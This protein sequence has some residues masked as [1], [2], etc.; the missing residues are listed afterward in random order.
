M[1][2]DS[3][4]S[5]GVTKPFLDVKQ[6]QITT[7]RSRRSWWGRR[8]SLEK[9]LL[10]IFL[11]FFIIALVTIILL[12]SQTKG[13]INEKTKE[14]AIC[15]SADCVSTASRVLE[16]MDTTVDPCD[17]FFQY[18]CGTWNRKNIIPDDR[19]HYN[20]FSKL[21]DELQVILKGLLEVPVSEEEAIGIRNAK[22]LYKSCLNMNLIE[23]RGDGPLK[24]L[25]RDIGGW[26]VLDATWDEAKFDWV[27]QAATLRLLNNRVL[28]NQWVSSDDK[29]SSINVIQLDQTQLGMPSRDYFLKE[30]REQVNAYQ[31][32]AQA[33]AEALGANPNTA[34]TEMADMVA[35]ESQ[36][37]NLTVP[38]D[39]RRDTEALYNRMSIRELYTN[40][41]DLID[42]HQYLNQIFHNVSIN[43]TMDD[44]VIVYAPDFLRDL[45]ELVKV[46]SKRTVA[47]YMTWRIVMN[48]VSNMPQKYLDLRRQYNKVLFGTDTDR[49]RWRTCVN[50]AIDNFGMAVGR[51]FVQK[52][53]NEE[54][55]TSALEMIQNIRA[56]FNELL[57]DVPW[58][59]ETTRDVAK[60]KADAIQEK[61]GYPDYIL[62]NTALDEDYEGME[63]DPEKY[64]ENVLKMLNIATQ[65][66]LKNLPRPVD[67]TK[68]STTPVIVNA[69]Y[70]ATKNQIM[71][72][73]AIFQP[74]FYLD[75]YPKS[76]NYGGIA[77]VI[78]HELTHS[79][80][81]RGRQFDKDGN[82]KQWWSDD[83]VEKFKNKAQCI[84]DQYDDYLVVEV[85]KTLNG[86]NTQG[87]NIADN[88]G[89][90]QAFRAYRSWVARRGKE[91]DLLPGV[92]LS[93]NQLFFL[94]FAQIWCGNSRPQSYIQAISSGRHSPG[95]F[96]VIGALSNSYDFAEAYKCPVGSSMNPQKKCSVW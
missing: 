14:Q 41:T 22:Y 47:N 81:D 7:N 53:F 25:L 5:A 74:P 62:N 55:K 94:N 23:E 30:D 21:R 54:A 10:C 52:Y 86:K 31:R 57:S 73:A 44:Q 48:R 27:S 49:A 77:V 58:M 50:Y 16:A 95:K 39:Q 42:W 32:Y 3:A 28:I 68:W 65:I 67:R 92:N 2:T 15:M 63:M 26:P 46:T 61:I 20:T 93:H 83:V 18:A 78:G 96:R 17:D 88:G 34:A 45:A 51:I 38:D 79:F 11:L 76:L 8:T 37:A 40:V 1:T 66:N 6:P 4:N 87:E 69:F 12:A 80:D 43:L 82:L 71:F 60:E 36:V 29:N 72:P 59:D 91:E 13:S 56:S 33:V 24:Q 19:S 84:I 9:I 70:S 75:T 90:K 85:N 64:F 35:F 89:L